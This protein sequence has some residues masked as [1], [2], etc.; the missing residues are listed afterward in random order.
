MTY[1][2]GILGNIAALMII[3]AMITWLLYNM[4]NDKR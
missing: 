3:A 4:L 1:W 2:M